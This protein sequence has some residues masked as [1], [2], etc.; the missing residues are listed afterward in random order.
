MVTDLT[1]LVAHFGFVTKQYWLHRKKNQFV[2]LFKQTFVT[3]RWILQ[4]NMPQ[5]ETAGV[6]KINC[7]V[8]ISYTQIHYSASL[9]VMSVTKLL[10]RMCGHT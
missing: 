9:T 6:I 7:S 8:Y 4:G 1:E 10:L 3:L 2:K 5:R